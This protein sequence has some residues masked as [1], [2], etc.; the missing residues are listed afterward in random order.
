MAYPDIFKLPETL[1]VFLRRLMCLFA[2]RSNNDPD[3]QITLVLNNLVKTLAAEA[4]G[5]Y[6]I[7]GD[8]L[9]PR[10][11]SPVHFSL[12]S[13]LQERFGGMGRLTEVLKGQDSKPWLAV[14]MRASGVPVGRLWLVMPPGHVFSNEERELIRLVGNQL[15]TTQENLRLYREVAY[16]AER[17]G[18]LLRR[19]INVQDER[20]RR[21]SRELHDEISPTLAALLIDVETIQARQP[22]AA[23]A[24]QPYLD[25]FKVG[26]EGAM[27]EI[28]RI[29]LDLRPALLE[30]QG[31]AAALNWFAAER[32]RPTGASLHVNAC[33]SLRL[34]SHLETTVYRIAQ[35]A[36]TNAA[37][38]SGAANVWLEVSC[39]DRTFVLAVRDDGCGFDVQRMLTQPESLQGIGLFGMKERAAL[40]GC[41]LAIESTAGEGTRVQVI[42]PLE[43]TKPHDQD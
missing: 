33:C 5:V 2:C 7:R 21:V 3:E 27:D 13:P 22:A 17:R 12:D 36:I 43:E 6:W 19:I 1:L 24:L 32:L 34:A 30:D 39:P 9:V 18:A 8:K 35:E 41:T 38:H 26:L 10:A 4:A 15:A 14:P 31:L 16:L 40:V 11:Q 25:R 23:E 42:V 29:V 20:C 28:N 37:R